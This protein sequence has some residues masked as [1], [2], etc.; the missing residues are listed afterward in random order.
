MWLLREASVI[1]L[2]VL[3]ACA[4]V[5]TGFASIPQMLAF[6]VLV[7]VIVALTMRTVAA[8]LA[9]GFCRWSASMGHGLGVLV[10]SIRRARPER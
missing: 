6:V 5:A 10:A 2:F 3:V 4:V 1:T 7:A 8:I 9:A